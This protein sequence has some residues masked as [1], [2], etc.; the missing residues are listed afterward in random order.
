MKKKR[1]RGRSFWIGLACL[2]VASVAFV[3]VRGSRAAKADNALVVTAKRGT[4]VIDILETGRVEARERVEIKSKVSG[5]V[6]RVLAE[7][8]ARV[9]KGELLATLDPTD[10][11]REVARA[12]AEL[13]QAEA[14]RDFARL[15]L[16]RKKD[17][18]HAR[19]L[20][21]SELDAAEHQYRTGEAALRSAKVALDAARDRVRYTRLDSPI[22][23]T[24]IQRGIEVGEVVTP[25]IQAT[26]EGKPLLTVADLSTLLVLVDLNQI[27]VAKVRLGQ[28]ASVTLD[29]LPNQT[30]EA[31]VTRVA[32]ASIKREH[33]DVEVFPIEATLAAPND[34]IKPG[35][36]ADVRI[37]LES[38]ADVL[39][40]PI[41][42]VVEDGSGARVT[43]LRRDERGEE[44]REPVNVVLGARNDREVEVSAGLADGDRVLV[45][46]ASAAK[47]EL[48]L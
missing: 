10:Y 4:L 12:Q 20:A 18:I 34:A 1:L 29:A 13:A 6:S 17:S 14:T 3:L 36:T 40:L 24:V 31:R 38:K 45:D 27:D 5:Q 25:G 28:R 11:E 44:L 32:P 33:K 2:I 9:Q 46:P 19:V 30:Y 7:E 47:N 23:G 26:F 16:A 43:R 35:M 21:A 39:T 15:N 42:A 37:H 41:E 22:T 8:G 48:K